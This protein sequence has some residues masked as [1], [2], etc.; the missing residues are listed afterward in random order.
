MNVCNQGQTLC[1][2]CILIYQIM[3][4]TLL[5]VPLFRHNLQVALMLRLLKLRNIKIIEI[6]QNSR[7][8]CDKMCAVDETHQKR[9]SPSNQYIYIL[10]F[11]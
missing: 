2:P 4:Q 11:V 1:S 8:F 7:S 9:L 10:I 6:T 3:L 5:H